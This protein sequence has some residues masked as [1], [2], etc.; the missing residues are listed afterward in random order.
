MYTDTYPPGRQSQPDVEHTYPPTSVPRSPHVVAPS[1][2]ASSADRSGSSVRPPSSG[3]MTTAVQDPQSA[4]GRQHRDSGIRF[5]EAGP[6]TL[7]PPEEVDVPP[8]YSER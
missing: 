3:K 8:V 7:P 1:A 5:G 6:S 2:A 4:Y